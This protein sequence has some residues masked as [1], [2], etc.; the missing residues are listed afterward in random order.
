MRVLC[1]P[2]MQNITHLLQWNTRT[3]KNSESS[4]A[5]QIHVPESSQT[6]PMSLCKKIAF[7]SYKLT[8][9]I[10]AKDAASPCGTLKLWVPCC[11]TEPAALLSG[12]VLGGCLSNE[13]QVLKKVSAGC[14]GQGPLEPGQQ[15]SVQK[16][17]LQPHHKTCSDLSFHAKFQM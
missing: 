3:E 14:M 11:Q 7:L 15:Y 1:T 17:G 2:L 6:F 4:A 10:A 16:V 13:T 8:G 5:T 12:P 9:I